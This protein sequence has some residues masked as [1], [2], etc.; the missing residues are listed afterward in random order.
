LESDLARVKAFLKSRAQAAGSDVEITKRDVL[1]GSCIERLTAKDA[2]SGKSNIWFLSE[3][4]KYIFSRIIDLALPKSQRLSAA[5]KDVIPANVAELLQGS[6]ASKGPG[7]AP[8]VIVE[9]SDFEC[10]YCRKA[11]TILRDNVMKAHKADVRLVFRNY[12]LS[13]HSW[14]TNAA[15]LGACIL[16]QDVGGFWA[17]HDY[18]FSHPERLSSDTYAQD[19]LRILTRNYPSLNASVA[20]SCA[21]SHDTAPEV[22]ADIKLGNTV[23]VSGTPTLFINGRR[24]AGAHDAAYLE[25]IISGSKI[26][27]SRLSEVN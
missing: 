2:R 5:S 11:A 25:R 23:G 1:P 20:L 26:A 4:H 21:S 13:S 14:A 17:Y 3:N 15:E 12:P 7:N 8:V 24:V 22:E 27:G 18:V 16:R 10:P 9:F 19:I 6:K